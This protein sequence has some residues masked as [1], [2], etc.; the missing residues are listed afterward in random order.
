MILASSSTEPAVTWGSGLFK[1]GLL[2]QAC[3]GSNGRY[4]VWGSG[5]SVH[6]AAAYV[7]PWDH[8]TP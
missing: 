7:S 1:Q 6:A 4:R 3:S 2:A 5:S 8:L